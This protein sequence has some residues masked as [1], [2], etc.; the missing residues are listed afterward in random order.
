MTR[1]GPFERAV[2]FVER[3]E[4]RCATSITSFD[5]GVLLCRPELPLVWALNFARL[6]RGARPTDAA[7]LAALVRSLPWPDLVPHRKVV[8]NDE[9]A[10]R[11][12]AAGFRGLGWEVERLL[13]MELAGPAPTIEQGASVRE[14][15]PEERAVALVDYLPQ[16]GDKYAPDVLD[17]LIASRGVVEDAVEAR[18]FGAFVDGKLASLCELYLEDGTAQIENVTTATPYRRRGLS[19]AVVTSAIAEARAAGGD[20]LFLIAD[21]DDWP[22]EMYARLGFEPI[23]VT[24]EF[25][26]AGDD[27]RPHTE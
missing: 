16:V 24:Y 8:V 22:K 10:G 18:R 15:S 12:L 23:G 26:L 7:E 19:K 4:D 1:A 9:A 5:G 17:Q 21:A 25:Q 3:V 20:F 14:V 11:R 6:H 2:A 13:F 27:A